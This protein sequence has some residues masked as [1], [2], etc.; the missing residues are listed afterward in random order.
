MKTSD[1]Q[2][3]FGNRLWHPKRAYRMLDALARRYGATQ[4][5]M[6]PTKRLLI[7]R[8]QSVEILFRQ[9]RGSG[10]VALQLV[11]AKLKKLDP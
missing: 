2:A 6:S 3:V 4:I 10:R 11:D 1:I 7:N 8:S 5:G 9:K